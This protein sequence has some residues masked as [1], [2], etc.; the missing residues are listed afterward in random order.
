[1]VRHEVSV[2]SVSKDQQ[3]RRTFC[4]SV[5]TAHMTTGFSPDDFSIQTVRSYDQPLPTNLS[6]HATGTETRKRGRQA[7]AG[8][9]HNNVPPQ[10]PGAISGPL[11]A[12][13]HPPQHHPH[14]SFI[15]TS[16]QRSSTLPPKELRRTTSNTK[17]I[18]LL[19]LLLR[20]PHSFHHYIHDRDNISNTNNTTNQNPT[21][22]P[23]H[24]A[25]QSK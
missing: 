15:V 16:P 18:L 3:S 17:H 4:R 1:M 14:P 8:P 24:H 12:A 11:R 20:A 25:P 21:T 10:R 7:T 9:N 19:H 2:Y 23:V 5:H 22:P 13:L 6:L